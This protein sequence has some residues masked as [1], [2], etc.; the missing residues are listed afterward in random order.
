MALSAYFSFFV[1]YAVCSEYLKIQH[2]GKKIV[3][4][5]K[6]FIIWTDSFILSSNC[7]VSLFVSWF[8][9]HRNKSLDPWAKRFKT[10]DK[11]QLSYSSSRENIGQ[12]C[13]RH[14]NRLTPKEFTLMFPLG[15]PH[16]TPP[17][18]PFWLCPCKIGLVPTPVNERECKWAYAQGQLIVAS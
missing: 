16:F 4:T 10:I 3:Y 5:L 12:I 1:F 18:S 13:P 11:L 8:L 15:F 2:L 14:G 6:H 9:S 7:C 17:I